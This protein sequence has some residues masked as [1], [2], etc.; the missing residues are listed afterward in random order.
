MAGPVTCIRFTSTRALF[1]QNEI[2]RITNL[3]CS[4]RDGN[5][6]QVVTTLPIGGSYKGDDGRHFLITPDDKD[7]W[8]EPADMEATMALHERVFGSC[9]DLAI[10]I[11]AMSKQTEDHRILGELSVALAEQVNGVISMGGLIIP[12]NMVSPL[13]SRSASWSDIKDRMQAFT[14]AT[15]GKVAAFPHVTSSGREWASHTVDAT[16]LRAWLVHPAFRMIK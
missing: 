3:V 4:R 8:Y 5:S 14:D 7:P 15:P 11:S 2:E 1:W 6:V 12:H 16:F 13:E 9:P 10:N